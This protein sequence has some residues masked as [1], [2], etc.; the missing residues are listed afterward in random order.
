M[1]NHQ[2]PYSLLEG[3]LF[4]LILQLPFPQSPICHENFLDPS[5]IL[6][7]LL[8]I[9]QSTQLNIFSYGSYI[10]QILIYIFITCVDS[11]LI[12]H[13]NCFLCSIS[14]LRFLHCPLFP[15]PIISSAGVGL[16]FIQYKLTGPFLIQ[17]SMCLHLLSWGFLIGAQHGK[18]MNPAY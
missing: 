13:V 9:P 7:F 15:F 6:T 1:L 3:L 16:T 10:F 12:H 2:S 14:Y 11:L 18:L 17:V 8:W 5:H 4:F